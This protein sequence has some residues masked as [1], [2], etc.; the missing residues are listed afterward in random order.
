MTTDPTMA[1]R[2]QR[3]RA[4]EE[5]N[6]DGPLLVFIHG[7]PDDD[8][9]WRRQ[10][11]VLGKRYRCLLL[12]L[13][14]FGEA[15]DKAGGYD[16]P[17]L[18]EWA[19]A[20]VDD[21]RKSDEPVTLITHDWGAYLG[22]CL[23]QARPGLITRMVAI[24]V[25]GHFERSG[26]KSSLIIMGYQWSLIA[27]WLLGGALPPLGN[28]CSRL[29]ARVLQVPE[30]QRSAVKSRANYL[31]FFFWRGLVLPPFRDRLLG[32]YIPHCPILYVYGK[33]KPVMFHSQTWLDRVA[34]SGGES[35]GMDNAGH[36]LMETNAQELN[37]HLLSW[38]SEP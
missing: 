32:H 11:A 31:Y 37:A 4:R 1:K 7:W 24:D 36:W 18:A 10:V 15:R 35:I 25:G 8:R 29:V 3:C 33:R 34:R 5:G 27:A 28:A 23:D 30:P 9:L 12:T 26:V 2:N 6:A 19:G 22:Y 17:A 21:H 38:L 14:N 20:C 13:P 16:F